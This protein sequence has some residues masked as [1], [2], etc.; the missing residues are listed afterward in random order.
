[1]ATS[2]NEQYV[3]NHMHDTNDTRL[4]TEHF[5]KSMVKISAMAW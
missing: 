2:E 3:N 4:L 5:C 1:M